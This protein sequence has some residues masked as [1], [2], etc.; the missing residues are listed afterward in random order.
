MGL[1]GLHVMAG[2]TNGCHARL[3]RSVFLS[4]NLLPPN[5]FIKDITTDISMQT[6]H[7]SAPTT[8]AVGH[9][10]CL[11]ALRPT[12]WQRPLQTPLR[13]KADEP[14]E[15]SSGSDS[16]SVLSSAAKI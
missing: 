12:R 8:R 16:Y 11:A 10:K 1:C 6:F 4:R 7:L 3:L 14:K 5:P 15:T 2:R 13:A 9:A